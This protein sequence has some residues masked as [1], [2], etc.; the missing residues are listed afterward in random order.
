M[1]L[2]QLPRL[3]GMA[4]VWQEPIAAVFHM[5]NTLIPLDIAFWDENMRIVDILHMMPCE[6][7]P[8][9]L[10]RPRHRFVGA[11][12]LNERVLRSEGVQLGDVVTLRAGQPDQQRCQRPGL[13]SS[14]AERGPQVPAW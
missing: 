6:E 5:K 11:V 14:S 13:M 12:E 2:R 7:D 1:F 9:P 3:E 8:C 4:F 10:Y